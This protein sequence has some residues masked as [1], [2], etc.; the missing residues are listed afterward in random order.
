MSDFITLCGRRIPAAD[1]D[2]NL[3]AYLEE[4][5]IPVTDIQKKPLSTA[6][7]YVAFC[8]GSDPDYAG[9]LINDHIIDGGEITD[10]MNMISKKVEES[11]FFRALQARTTENIE[12]SESEESE[13]V[14]KMTRRKTSDPQD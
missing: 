9:K 2:F 5:N 10:I 13:K 12:Q 3:V 1:A 6:K 14:T 8:L 11:G 4:N 7:V